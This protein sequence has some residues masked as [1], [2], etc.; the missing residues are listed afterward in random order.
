MN[1]KIWLPTA[2]FAFATCTYANKSERKICEGFLPKSSEPQPIPA[3]MGFDRDGIT[4]EEF[5]SRN[6]LAKK[7]YSPIIEKYGSV[8]KLESDWDSPIVNASAYKS[9][10]DEWAITMLGGM[11]RVKGM[12]AD[13]YTVV[14]CHELGHLVGGFPMYPDPQVTAL[15]RSASEENSDYYAGFDCFYRMFKDDKTG[16]EKAEKSVS[17]KIKN[18]CEKAHSDKTRQ[19]I[20]MR[21]TWAGE[22]LWKAV[23]G[24][25][26]DD[27]EVGK[28]DPTVVTKTIHGYPSFQCRINTTTAAS[29]CSKQYFG[30]K[31]FPLN[32]K[33]MDL[34][35]CN[36]IDSDNDYLEGM[37]PNCWFNR[38]S[39]PMELTDSS[40]LPGYWNSV[41]C[42]D[43]SGE[44]FLE[45]HKYHRRFSETLANSGI[46]T[47]YKELFIGSNDCT[48]PAFTLKDYSKKF[49]ISEKNED[50]IREINY[51]Y[52]DQETGK[53]LRYEFSSI[54][55]KEKDGKMEL[56]FAVSSEGKNG[57]SKETRKVKFEEQHSHELKKVQ[58][59]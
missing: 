39:I 55:I 31:N 40:K 20:C 5:D 11:A 34:L 22:R 8:F 23:L 14:L 43:I 38:N 13:S 45:S 21:S 48:G 51:I 25:K 35:S 50:D 24:S 54:K 37:R 7:I 49:K 3:G 1:I 42:V 41:K 17:E 18:L 33:E 16:N 29:L 12:T 57:N 9:G 58:S 56:W 6:S 30:E 36:A 46:L 52:A 47:E 4:K 27:L 19:Q 53:N 44:G 10:T 59:N 28:K 2:I 15:F 26:G 32:L